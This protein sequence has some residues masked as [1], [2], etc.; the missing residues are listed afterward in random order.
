LIFVFLNTN[1][2]AFCAHISK[3]R[4]NT[5]NRRNKFSLFAITALGL[6]LLST[7][8]L[9]QQ[10]TL[11][12]QLVATWTITSWEQVLKD[13]TKRQ[14]FGPNP[15][16]VASFDAS[17]HFFFMF[18][19]PDLPKIA[20][21]DRIKV[22]PQEAQ[23]INAGSLAYFGTYAVDDASKTITLQIE[24]STYPNQLSVS[25]KRVITAL[26]PDELKLT[27]ATPTA[28]DGSAINISFRRAK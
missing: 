13:G 23:A 27:N 9:A 10:K 1:A 12:D 17:G 26:T 14:D 20:A 25:Q 2:S 18:A 8:V 11:K 16:G 28:G 3:I 7:S 21:T 19:K 5:M 4:R 24:T 22:T 15:K 6:A